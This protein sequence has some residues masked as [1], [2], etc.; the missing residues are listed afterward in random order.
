MVGDME[1]VQVQAMHIQIVAALDPTIKHV[2]LHNHQH[3]LQRLLHLPHHRPP[4]KAG[5]MKDS[6][7]RTEEGALAADVGTKKVRVQMKLLPL[8]QQPQHRHLQKV[9][10]MKDSLEHMGEGAPA[11]ADAGTKNLL[12]NNRQKQSNNNISSTNVEMI[13]TLTDL[14]QA[15]VANLLLDNLNHGFHHIDERNHRLNALIRIRN[16]CES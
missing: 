4:Q 7:A 15:A 10:E 6:P 14:H 9:G 5:G 2:N 16:D 13:M 8:Q 1:A 3:L 12:V 11:V